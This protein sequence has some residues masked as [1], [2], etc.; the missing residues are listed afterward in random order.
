MYS[1]SHILN[2]EL[3]Y[4]NIT[5]LLGKDPGEAF[6]GQTNQH[7]VIERRQTHRDRIRS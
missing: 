2:D 7:I 6:G 5:Y 3:H 1:Y 4:Y